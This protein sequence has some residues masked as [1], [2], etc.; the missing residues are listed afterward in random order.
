MDPPSSFIFEKHPI[1]LEASSFVKTKHFV[2]SIARLSIR[3]LFYKTGDQEKVIK[4]P[5]KEMHQRL[6]HTTPIT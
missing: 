1:P 5:R 4:L 2:F 3:K 6:K